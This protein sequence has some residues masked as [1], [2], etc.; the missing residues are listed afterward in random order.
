MAQTIVQEKYRSAFTKSELISG[1]V[2]CAAGQFNRLG[3]YVVKAGEAISVGFGNQSGQQN[4]QGRI[5]IDLKD[6]AAA[7][8]ANTNGLLRMV[9]YS[10]QDR[11]VEIIW[12]AR[13]ESLRTNSSDRTQQNPYQ[14]HD[15]MVPEDK[16]LV[17]EFLPDAAVTVGKANS[18][19]L[20]DITR[21]TVR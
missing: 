10:P 21:F 19:V 5:Y 13:T 12:E 3:A 11:P 18:T 1:D 17:L 9:A 7:P 2:V 16:K 8:G 14:E 15:L 4:A 6:N 20:M